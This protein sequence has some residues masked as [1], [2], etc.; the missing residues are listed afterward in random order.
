MIRS[1]Y[2]TP[3]LVVIAFVI[4]VCS[5]AA[6]SPSSASLR[7]VNFSL[8]STRQPAND[9]LL[10]DL[11]GRPVSV[12]A[13]KG[14]VVIL[15]FWRID[16][17]P[18]RIE[19][20]ILER[21][22]RKYA[23]RGLTILAVNLT[24][25]SDRVAQYVY[26]GGYSF[27]FA[28][29]PHNRLSLRKHTLPSGVATSFVINPD[30]E[31][32]YEIKGVPT[33]YLIDREGN[34]VGHSVG[35]TNWERG[36]LRELLE[37]L[38][39]PRTISASNPKRF[40][41]RAVIEAEGARVVPTSNSVSEPSPN[42][43]A[44][45]A[46]EPKSR[47]GALLAQ[48]PLPMA[49]DLPPKSPVVVA[50]STPA[51]PAALPEENRPARTSASNPEPLRSSGSA[52]RRPAQPPAA[53]YS[54]QVGSPTR[55]ARPRY[56]TSSLRPTV[57]RTRGPQPPSVRQPA[58]SGAGFRTRGRQALPELPRALP[59]SRDRS[60]E[61]SSELGSPLT[62]D[63][64][65]YVTARIPERSRSP[66]RTGSGFQSGV[67]ESGTLP[68]AMRSDRTLP[69]A[70]PA[71]AAN[72]IGNFILESFSGYSSPSALPPQPIR[73]QPPAQQAQPQQQPPQYQ[74]PSLFGR[75][76]NALSRI[77]PFQ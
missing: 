33:T 19:K 77:N 20:P 3:L 35:L 60:Q 39:G 51:P 12:E 43:A 8:Y 11:R 10:S 52:I 6:L 13:L 53:A 38:V 46:K 4:P 64:N 5:H 58:Q 17:P 30:S 55:A 50:P 26:D 57:P 27:T 24:D 44:G 28:V 42:M 76:T 14:Q 49:G 73:V 16:C 47:A 71:P 34:L 72:P 25:S 48:H 40:T 41:P 62:P 32:I 56:G 37:S 45:P 69:Q 9:M 59:Y 15:N 7:A 23:G 61:K 67:P 1:R 66:Q 75:I 21:I 36:P 65:G 74:A 68:P 54:P 31:A 70:Q 2:S 22:H 29:D 63:K 18:C